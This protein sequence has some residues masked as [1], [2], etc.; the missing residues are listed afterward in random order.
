MFLQAVELEKFG[1][2]TKATSK[3]LV[4]QAILTLTGITHKTTDVSKH[5]EKKEQLPPKK[6]PVVGYE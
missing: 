6:E 1:G 2:M 4:D 5:R 3:T